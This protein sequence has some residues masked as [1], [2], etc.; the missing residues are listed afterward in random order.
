MRPRRH[1]RPAFPRRPRPTSGRSRPHAPAYEIGHMLTAS[2]TNSE[3]PSSVLCIE[4][5]AGA[6]N[7]VALIVDQ[8]EHT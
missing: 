8:K 1:R 7:P 3:L 2:L 5:G 6:V 4:T